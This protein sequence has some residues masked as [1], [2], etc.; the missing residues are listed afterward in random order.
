RPGETAEATLERQL[1]EEIQAVARGYRHAGMLEPDG[2]KLGDSIH[3]FSAKLSTFGQSEANEAIEK[4]QLVTMSELRARVRSNEL[5][6]AL[7]LAA[8][9]KV[10]CSNEEPI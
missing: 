4:A 8:L 3:L 2:G 5:T 6:D 9:A 1:S 10:L 7:T